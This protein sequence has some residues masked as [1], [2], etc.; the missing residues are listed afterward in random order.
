[1]KVKVYYFKYKMK[2]FITTI[3]ITLIGLTR[4]APSEDKVT[5]LE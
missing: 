2:K 4:C 5:A 1:M 3:G